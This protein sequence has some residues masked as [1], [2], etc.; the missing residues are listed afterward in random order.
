MGFLRRF[1]YLARLSIHF[2]N[3]GKREIS[4]RFKEHRHSKEEG[5][6]KVSER[7]VVLVHE[8]NVKRSNWKMG[9]VVGLITGKDGED[10]GAELKLIT[11]GKAIFVIRALQKLYPLEVCSV[12]TV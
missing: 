10:R 9:K 11:K 5:L 1:R 12:T 6:R 2:W 3:W 4:S 8:D 7:D